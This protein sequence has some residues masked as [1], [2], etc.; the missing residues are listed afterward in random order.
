MPTHVQTIALLH[1]GNAQTLHGACTTDSIHG[2]L[3]H[4]GIRW[5]TNTMQQIWYLM[6]KTTYWFQI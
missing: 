3:T 4:H 2:V 5:Q 6:T 1:Q